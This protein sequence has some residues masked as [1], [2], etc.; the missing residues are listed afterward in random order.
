MPLT[1]TLSDIS[2]E[3]WSEDI[4][5]IPKLLGRSE[6]ADIRLEDSTISREHCKFWMEDGECYLEDCGSS[7]G[8]YVNGALIERWILSRGD[9]ILVGK[10]ELTVAEKHQLKSTGE[11]VLPDTGKSL[12][13]STVSVK[14]F[15]VMTSTVPRP[16]AWPND[17][18]LTA[19]K[20]WRTRS[21]ASSMHKPVIC[22]TM[23]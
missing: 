15:V 22:W 11:F 6:D 16:R 10:F 13:Q 19:W 3:T 17:F 5:S 7:N 8:T 4:T 9:K 23:L 12:S 20:A 14:Q 21:N 18:R 1:L 2:P